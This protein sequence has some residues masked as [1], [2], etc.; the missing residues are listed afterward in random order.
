MF[1]LLFYHLE[2]GAASACVPF[3]DHG[4]AAGVL[5][6]AQAH[7]LRNRQ[8]GWHRAQKF[9]LGRLFQLTQST[10]KKQ[11]RHRRR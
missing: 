6:F 8:I 5:I 10:R 9:N 2:A 7:R 4:N 1:C 3:G 11:H